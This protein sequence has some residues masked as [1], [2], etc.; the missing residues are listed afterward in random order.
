MPLPPAPVFLLGQTLQNR[1]R[2]SPVG[3]ARIALGERPPGLLL[4]WDQV[5]VEGVHDGRA[6]SAPLQPVL[7]DPGVGEKGFDRVTIQRKDAANWVGAAQPTTATEWDT[8]IDRALDAQGALGVDAQIISSSLLRRPDWPDGLQ[9]VLDAARRTWRRRGGGDNFVRVAVEQAWLNDSRQRRTLLNQ[10]TDLPRELG[11][12]LHVSWAKSAALGDEECIENLRITVDALASDG[13]RVLLL[14]GGALGWLAIA[15]GAWG[16]TAGIAQ[17]TWLRSEETILRQKGQKATR[18]EWYFE[19]RLFHRVRRATHRR[20]LERRDYRQCPCRFCARLDAGG[21]TAWDHNLAA[22]HALFSLAALTDQVAAPRLRDRH[23][24]VRAAVYA[25]Q[26]YAI[27][28]GLR[29]EAKPDHL[30]SWLNQL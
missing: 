29:G 1:D 30:Q 5:H 20:L 18:V 26:A 9:L 27:D 16:F 13:R 17:S 3:D 6:S 8:A 19:P 12:A 7:A 21:T 22:Q 4:S 24:R 28:A 11:V 2:L 14:E 15:W 25:A 23:A 10:I